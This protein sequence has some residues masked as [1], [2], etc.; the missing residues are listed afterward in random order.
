MQQTGAYRRCPARAGAQAL[1]L[2]CVFA[3]AAAPDD[4]N[5]ARGRGLT[6]AS[7]PPATEASVFDAV[8]HASF[9]VEPSLV[10]LMHPLRLPR[11]AGYDGGDPIPDGLVDALRERGIVHGVCTP[12]HEAPRDT[13]RCTGPN[14][15]YVV[16]ASQPFHG[17][18][19]TIQ[20]NFAAEAFGAEVGSRPQALRFEKIY[21]LIGSGSH[22]R[23]V[24]EARAREPNR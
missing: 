8:V 13:P 11:M 18:G 21:Q 7:F 12:K 6:P 16:R 10:L 5:V 22:W 20:I 2:W 23:V 1:L 9:N 19:D 3:C 17:A 4:S 14:A 15:G 24:R